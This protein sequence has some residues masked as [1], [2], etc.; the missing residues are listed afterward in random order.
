MER[1]TTALRRLL[2]SSGFIY[3]PSAYD[4]IGGR[5][6]ASLGFPAVYTGGFVTGGSRCTSE[7]L[8]T[9]DEQ[10]RVAGDVAAAVTVP[11]VADGGAGFGEPLHTMRSVRE[12]IRAGIA[13]IHIEDQL[14][15]KRAHYHKYVAHVT[16]RD[17]FV[18]KI[19]YACR[20][21]AEFG[22]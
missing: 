3:M 6:I 18:T 17:E 15:P 7:P 21:R 12:F 20:Q 10:V 22:S 11:L 16:P 4:A 2:S 14:Y 1:T 9:M 5:L 13:G 8:L 19:E